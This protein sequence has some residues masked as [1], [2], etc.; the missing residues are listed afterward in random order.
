MEEKSDD[1]KILSVLSAL[2]KV[3]VESNLS[4]KEAKKI[5]SFFPRYVEDE[6]AK[7]EEQ[8]KF[9]LNIFLRFHLL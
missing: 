3:M 9:Y 2:Y 8:T 5:A 6:I 1:R 4:I 7:K